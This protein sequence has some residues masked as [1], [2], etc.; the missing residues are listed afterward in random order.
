VSRGQFDRQR[1]FSPFALFVVLSVIAIICLCA[2]AVISH[3]AV[4]K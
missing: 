2:V 3:P 4:A 1:E